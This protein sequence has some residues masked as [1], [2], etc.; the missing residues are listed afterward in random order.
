[1]S[2]GLIRIRSYASLLAPTGREAARLL[3]ERVTTAPRRVYVGAALTAL[4]AGIGANALLQ[5]IG[6]HPAPFL[7]EASGDPAPTVQPVAPHA[8][9]APVAPHMSPPPPVSPPSPPA[10]DF[11]NTAPPAAP[12]AAGRP[13]ATRTSAPDTTS[14]LGP[15]EGPERGGPRAAAHA[16]DQIAALLRGKPV[17]DESRLVRAAQTALV[18]LGYPVKPIGAEDGA[19]RRALREFER[20]HGLTPTTKISPE[21]VKQLSA[22]ARAGG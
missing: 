17:D 20:A 5:Q 13:R 1:M 4:L 14:S 18:K 12:P 11:V 15:A 21:L 22:A 9:P 8:S 7:A 10:A 19:T 3:I 6:R 2:E 16:P